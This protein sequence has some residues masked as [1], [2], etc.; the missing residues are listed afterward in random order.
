MSYSLSLRTFVEGSDVPV[1]LDMDVVRS[2]LGPYET[3]DPALTVMEDGWLQF[4][5]RASD[6]SEAEIFADGSSVLVERPQSGTGV[7]GIIAELAARLRAVVI[8]PNNGVFLCDEETYAQLPVAMREDSVSVEMTGEA[9]TA[10]LL[11]PRSP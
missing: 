1:P 5:V 11:G 7:F 3:G 2:V 8:D 4:W 9:L 10:A 6:G